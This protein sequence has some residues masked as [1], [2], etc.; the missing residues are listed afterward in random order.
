[1]PNLLYRAGSDC[2]VLVSRMKMRWKNHY[3]IFLKK[4]WARHSHRL[5][6]SAPPQRPSISNKNQDVELKQGLPPDKD[7]ACHFQIQF[8]F[9]SELYTSSVEA[10]IWSVASKQLVGPNPPSFFPEYTKPE[11]V[12]YVYRHHEFWTSGFFPGC[13][14]LL[15]ERR[16]K[17]AHGNGP[18]LECKSRV[19]DM[20]LE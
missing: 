14:H 6:I 5:T 11:G 9:I 15:L 8:K 18:G 7:S 20:Q 4:R 19:N 13:L 16:K 2:V 17:Y 1:M 3:L 10:K 12:S